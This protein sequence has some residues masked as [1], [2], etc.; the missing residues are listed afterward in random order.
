MAFGGSSQA[1]QNREPSTN[2]APKHASDALIL[3]SFSMF[4]LETERFLFREHRH[5]D[6]GSYCVRQADAELRRYLG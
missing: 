6:L 2:S 5:S 3:D 4:I 1:S